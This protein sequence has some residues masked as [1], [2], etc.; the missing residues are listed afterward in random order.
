M[1]VNLGIEKFDAVI[2]A[3]GINFA[4]AL[5]GSYLAAVKNAP[6]LLAFSTD[7]INDQ[8]KD[9]IRN[10]LNPGGTVYILGGESAVPASFEKGLDGF[11]INRLAGDN[12]FHTNLLV[13]EEAG[14]G[15]KPVL[16]C[17]GL[18]FADS[19]SASATELPILLVW[20]NLTEGQKSFLSSLNGNELYVIGGKSAV[21]SAMEQQLASYGVTER[22]QGGN[23]FETS[24]AIAER[25]FYKPET[26]VL[27]YAW[28]FPDGLCGG[29]LAVSMDA[30]LILTM[31]K[32]EVRAAEYVQSQPIRKATILGGEGLI[33]E[34]AAA[35]IL[36]RA[37]DKDNAVSVY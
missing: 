25:F 22:V 24:V 37:A 33:S 13:L 14:V 11:V 4:D 31:D 15:D 3:S 27:A 6:I 29:P 19:L 17:T 16:V 30:P 10:N 7:A 35:T 5:S 23:R 21:S 8:V 12:R 26:V 20:N 1:K 36:V 18:S 2:V 9:Y 28:N 32:Y 34:K